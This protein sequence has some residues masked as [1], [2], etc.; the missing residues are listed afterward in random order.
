MSRGVGTEVSGVQGGPLTAGAQHVDNGVGTAPIGGAGLATAKP[1]GVLVFWDQAL[2]Q[3]PQFIRYAKRCCH[4][5]YRRPRA[6]LS[7]LCH[8]FNLAN[9]GYPDSL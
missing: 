3:G 2:E 5:V 8:L 7:Y 4:F 9:L 6:P 1:V